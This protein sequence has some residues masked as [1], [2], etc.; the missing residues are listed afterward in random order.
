MARCLMVEQR[1]DWRQALPSGEGFAG[2][3]LDVKNHTGFAAHE[4][5]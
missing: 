2:A 1:N 3:K 5:I 4:R